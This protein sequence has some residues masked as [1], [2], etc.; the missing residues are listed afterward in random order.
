[1]L[2][3]KDLYKSFS[4][5]SHP[6]QGVSFNVKAGEVVAL[7]GVSG[8]G[9]S[10]LLNIVAGIESL[11]G[12]EVFIGD[13]KL[14][15]SYK[16]VDKIRKE[17]IGIVFQQFLLLSKFTV[18][19]QLEFTT[20]ASAKEILSILDEL[21]LREQKDLNVESC[22]GGQQQRC[23]IARALVKKPKVILADE[24]TANL[25]ANLA[26]KS[27]EL[28]TKVAKKNK[29]AVLI[30]THDERITPLCDKVYLLKGGKIETR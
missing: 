16:S 10:T 8:S 29:T 27:L 19:Q 30:V 4:K 28:L 13:E 15:F 24:P 6:L 7:M 22:S 18:F 26:L 23:A 1:M 21:E 5:D 14:D 11:D 17:L 12:G 3:I 25:D 20:G 2:E 9:K